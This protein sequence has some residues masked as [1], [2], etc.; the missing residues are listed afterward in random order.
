[1]NKDYIKERVSFYKEVLKIL[2]AFLVA[3]AGGTVSLLFRRQNELV[4]WLAIVGTWL[5]LTLILMIVG[6]MVKIELLLR[7]LKDG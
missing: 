7:E 3:S 6:L 1:M 2:S 4:H 5:S